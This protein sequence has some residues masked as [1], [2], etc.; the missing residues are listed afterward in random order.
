MTKKKRTLNWI[1]PVTVLMSILWVLF[2]PIV[3]CFALDKK[4]EKYHCQYEN[5]PAI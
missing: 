3:F 2:I 1:K 5:E 4:N